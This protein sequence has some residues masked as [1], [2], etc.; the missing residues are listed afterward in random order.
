MELLNELLC[1]NINIIGNSKFTVS[2]FKRIIEYTDKKLIIETSDFRLR[3]LGVDFLVE[4]MAEGELSVG[5]HIIS[6]E[7]LKGHTE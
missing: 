7:F 3:L 6:L 5:G 1:S 4:Y 2:N